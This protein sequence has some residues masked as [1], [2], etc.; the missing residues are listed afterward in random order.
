MHIHFLGT[1]SGTEP[2][3]GMHHCAW[4]FRIGNS[5]YWFDMGEGCSHTAYTAG[6]DVMDT[7][8]IFVSHPHIDHVGGF[9][10][11][12]F[13]VMKLMGRYKKTLRHG[14]IRL[15]FPDFTLLSAIKTVA[16][17]RADGRLPFPLAENALRDGLLYEDENVRVTAIHNGHMGVPKEGEP[18]RSYSFLIEAEGK[19]IVFSGDVKAPSD[20]DPLLSGGADFL[21]METGHHRVSDVCEYAKEKEVKALRFNHHGRE[22]IEHRESVQRAIDAYARESGMSI[23]LCCDGMQETL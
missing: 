11:F 15:F 2:M 23:V 4:L 8:A 13:C 20:L 22:I 18:Y 6:I 3:V 17:G 7:R 19:R 9:A 12:L 14:E 1:C 5:I 21:I 16:T 10:N